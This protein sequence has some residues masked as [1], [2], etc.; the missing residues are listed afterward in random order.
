MVPLLCSLCLQVSALNFLGA[1][2]GRCFATSENY[3][4][5]F[6]VSPLAAHVQDGAGCEPPTDFGSY[7]QSSW[8]R[9]HLRTQYAQQPMNYAK[10]GSCV[11]RADGYAAQQA[12]TVQPMPVYNLV[13]VYK[14]IRRVAVRRHLTEIRVQYFLLYTRAGRDVTGI[15]NWCF[16]SLSRD[17][18]RRHQQACFCKSSTNLAAIVLAAATDP[19]FLFT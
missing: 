13:D 10:A 3:A 1:G 9:K 2:F 14:T 5:E 7:D 19:A 16:M 17:R 8:R 15:E 12:Y 6:A 4:K 11:R 18:C